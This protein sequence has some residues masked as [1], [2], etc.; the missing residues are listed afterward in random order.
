MMARLM[1]NHQSRTRK[2]ARML[3]AESVCEDPVKKATAS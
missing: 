3:A 1:T 2:K